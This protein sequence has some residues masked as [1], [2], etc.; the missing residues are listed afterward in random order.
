M[1]Y[2]NFRFILPVLLVILFFGCSKKSETEAPL[3]IWFDQ[4]SVNWNEGLPVGNGSLGGM[5]YGLPEKE[6]ITLNEETI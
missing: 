5:I 3:K 1:Y 2:R 6:Q 4:P